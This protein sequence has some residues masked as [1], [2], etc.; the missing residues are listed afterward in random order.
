MF[1]PIV[2]IALLGVVCTA[3]LELAERR[4]VQWRK[5]PS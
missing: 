5:S 3:L 2:V 4:L 1:V